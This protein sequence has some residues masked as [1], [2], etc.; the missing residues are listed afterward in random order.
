MEWS[1]QSF[2]Y[3]NT[4][5]II[6]SIL[7]MVTGVSVGMLIVPAL[8]IVSYT[9]VPVPIVFASL[10]LTM[11]MTYKGRAHID[12][13]H[14]PQ[15]AVGMLLGIVVALFLFKS[16]DKQNI[17]ILFGIAILLSV[18]ISLKLARFKLYRV[19]K[20]SGGFIAGVMGAIAAVGGQVLA[21][22]FQNHSLESIKAS[23]ALLYTLFSLV[24]LTLFYIAGEFHSTQM[25]SGLYMMPGF[26]I[27]F[28]IA[29]YFAKYFHPKYTKTVV[30][31][32]ATLGGVGLIVKGFL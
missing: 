3:V 17:G 5:I 15:I 10:T 30:L 11:M 28:L 20:Y 7:Q 9:L 4:V 8:A 27:G 1:F 13:K 18:I 14:I 25:L 22:L 16:I 12:M 2:I 23:L 26:L 31:G 19:V 24:M 21:L 6:S 29:P 32:M